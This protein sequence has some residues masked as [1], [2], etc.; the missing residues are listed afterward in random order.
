MAEAMKVT[1][2]TIATV[3]TIAG[4]IVGVIWAT[5]GKDHLIHDTSD[6]VVAMEPEV[7][8]NT[9][10]RIGMQKDIEHINE[11]IGRIEGSM[12]IIL[13]KMP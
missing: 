9:E 13:E 11:G 10:A 8:Q 7:K 3:M 5:A 12:K 1:I 2:K 4:I 6:K